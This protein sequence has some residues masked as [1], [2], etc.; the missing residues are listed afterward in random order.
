MPG[1]D[2]EDAWDA[3]VDEEG[4][5]ADEEVIQIDP[6]NQLSKKPISNAAKPLSKKRPASPTNHDRQ[7]EGIAKSMSM[8][9][10][11]S[12]SGKSRSTCPICSKEFYI[13]N[14][15]FNAHIDFCLSK[16]VIMEATSA[17][18][19]SSKKRNFRKI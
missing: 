16:G 11:F 3:T 9:S 7:L 18:P 17:K 13:D 15:A 10:V 8:K 5:E 1:F 4:G 14:A 19:S 6:P 12:T 2:D